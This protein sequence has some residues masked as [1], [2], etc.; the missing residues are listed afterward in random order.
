MQTTSVNQENERYCEA[1]QQ[2]GG[3]RRGCPECIEKLRLRSLEERKQK[4]R[5]LGEARREEFNNDHSTMLRALYQENLSYDS[6]LSDLTA[7]LIIEKRSKQEIKSSEARFNIAIRKLEQA[8]MESLEARSAVSVLTGRALGY[9][10]ETLEARL[11]ALETGEYFKH[12]SPP[13]TERS[14]DVAD[15][16]LCY[17]E[18]LIAA[19]YKVEATKVARAKA[20][21]RLETDPKQAAK[22]KAKELWERWQDGHETHKSGAAFALHIV[23]KLPDLESV[24]VVEKWVTQWRK[25]RKKQP[26]S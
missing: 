8:S 3:R 11:F 10:S 15:M 4:V 24:K 22:V 7:L 23:N 16:I 19:A 6:I 9:R 5:L 17:S 26:S 12:K 14:Y 13:D 1:C 25:D 21:K 20:I 2:L 18:N